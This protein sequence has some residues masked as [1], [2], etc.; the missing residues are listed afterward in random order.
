MNWFKKHADSIAVVAAI[1]SSIWFMNSKMNSIEEKMDTKF[2]AMFATMDT[3]LYALE[4]DMAIIKTVLLMK[5][6]YPKE[7]ATV[8]KQD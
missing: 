4:K 1:F 7:L 5:D 3:R 8:E 2:S 6:I